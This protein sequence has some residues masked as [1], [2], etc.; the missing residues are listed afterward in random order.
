MKREDIDLFEVWEPVPGYEDY[1]VSSYG[2]V[3]SKKRRILMKQ[4]LNKTGYVSVSLM[5]DGIPKF[6]LIHRLVASVFIDNPYGL[7]T[8]NHKDEDKTNNIVENLEW[9]S[10]GYNNTYGTRMER[11][12]DSFIR[13]GMM[14]PENRGLTHAQKTKIWSEKNRDKVRERQRRYRAR[15]RTVKSLK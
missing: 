15:Q 8:V 6:F 12:L 1:E 7:P 14:K 13:I 4:K 3:W 2:R 11:V 9:C 5:K 10:Q